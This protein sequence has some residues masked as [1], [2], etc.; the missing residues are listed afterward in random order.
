MAVYLKGISTGDFQETLAALLGD[1]KQGLSASTITRLK[2]AWEKDYDAWAN[3]SFVGKR[4][5]YIWAD[6]VYFNLRLSED[7]R[8]CILVIMGTT[9]DGVKELIAVF[10]GYRESEMSWIEVMLSLQKRGLTTTPELAICD[11]ALGF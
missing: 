4:Y 5:I 1:G 2:A 9:V 3:R 6:G 11:G 8:M 10:P 7:E